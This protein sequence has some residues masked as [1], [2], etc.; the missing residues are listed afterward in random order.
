MI[1]IIKDGSLSKS[2]KIIYKA[3]CPFCDCVF[4]FEPEDI[5]TQ[6]RRLNGFITVECPYCHEDISQ[7][8]FKYRLEEIEVE[9][10]E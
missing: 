6:E 7:H 5:K 2:T 10:N 9:D 8:N 3:T 1:K 4:E